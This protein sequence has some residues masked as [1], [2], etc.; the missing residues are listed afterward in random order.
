VAGV[1]SDAP[2][3]IL[4]M[5]SAE[6]E[7]VA[8]TGRVVVNVD[9]SAGAIAVGDLL[10]TSDRPGYAM[11]S[12]PVDVSGIAMHRPGTIVGKALQ[13]LAAGEGQILVLLSLQ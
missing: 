5:A 13:P 4:G 3:I 10:V 9:A 1:I 2:G 11:K 12:M 7:R 6:K 8:T